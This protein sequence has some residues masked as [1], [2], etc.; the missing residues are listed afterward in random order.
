MKEAP[1]I[2]L[3]RNK[4]G[5]VLEEKLAIDERESEICNALSIGSAVEH[6]VLMATANLKAPQLAGRRRR[7]LCRASLDMDICLMATALGA[8][9][10]ADESPRMRPRK[11]YEKAV[12]I[13]K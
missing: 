11:S 2:I 1:V 13:R 6:M 4:L 10:Y 7:A 5:K 8:I 12:T 9:G 3:I